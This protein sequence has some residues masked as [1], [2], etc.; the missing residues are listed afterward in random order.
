MYVQVHI[1]M[2]ITRKV[3]DG[4]VMQWSEYPKNRGGNEASVHTPPLGGAVTPRMGPARLHLL[5]LRIYTIQAVV[6][7]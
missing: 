5:N 4:S 7:H 3:R 6:T 2:K 1:S